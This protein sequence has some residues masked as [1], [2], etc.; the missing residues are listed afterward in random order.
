MNTNNQADIATVMRDI[1][2]KFGSQ[3]I[4]PFKTFASQQKIAVCSTGFQNIDE[5]TGLGGL[6]AGYTILYF[7]MATSGMT[8]LAY[9]TIAAAQKAGGVIIYV[10]MSKT[11]DAEYAHVACGVDGEHL[12]YI[13]IDEQ[14]DAM[15]LV[16]DLISLS[17]SGLI[18]LDIGFITNKQGIVLPDLIDLLGSIRVLL[19]STQ[20]TVLVMLPASF[21]RATANCGAIHLTLKREAWIRKHHAITGYETRVLVAKNTLAPTQGHGTTISIEAHMP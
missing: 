8:T 9:H 12:L 18:V 4:Q 20:W 16:R 3:A 13:P 10:D 21:Q 14:R 19:R 6:P 17:Y 2:Q 7:G 1:N 11:F 15:R 5:M